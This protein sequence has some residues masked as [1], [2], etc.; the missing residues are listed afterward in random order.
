MNPSDTV[1]GAISSQASGD[2]GMAVLKKALNAQAQGATALVGAL[3]Q[4]TTKPSPPSNLPA[5]LG[6]S[7]NTTA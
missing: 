1:V 5:H 2:V 7:V 3:P 6:R 4:P